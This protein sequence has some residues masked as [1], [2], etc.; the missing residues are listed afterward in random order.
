[1]NAEPPKNTADRAKP[2]QATPTKASKASSYV[3][4]LLIALAITAWMFTGQFKADTGAVA[5]AQSP[6]A[7][8]QSK[9]ESKPEKLFR[10]RVTPS[11]AEPRTSNLTIR[12][13]TKAKA[14]VQ[15]RAETAGKVEKIAVK[16]GAR[17][18]TGDLLCQ[19]D[20]GTRRATMAE[21][22]ASRVQ[23]QGDFAS[24][25]KLSRS[26]FTAVTKRRADKARLDAAKAAYARAELDMERTKVRAP[27]DG[28]VEA[29]PVKAGDYLRAT[30]IC[31]T[32][33]KLDPIL[34][35]GAIPE[36]DVARVEVGMNVR[37]ELV[38]GEE[39]TG[40]ITFISPSA[41]TNTRTFEF[42][43]EAANPKRKL[44][45]GVTADIII[46]L[47]AS[48]AHR[49][50]AS[51]LSLDDNGRIGLRLVSDDQTVRFMPVT[52]LSN[53]NDAV[54]VSGLPQTAQVITV[55]QE[56]VS[57]GQRVEAVRDET[58]ADG[59]NARLESESSAAL[60]SPMVETSPASASAVQRAPAVPSTE[61]KATRVT[62]PALPIRKPRA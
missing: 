39:V 1:M 10:V 27:F 7:T 61:K 48:D 36:R 59:D 23:A 4:A 11:K 33:V 2:E 17:V 29:Q 3:W 35:T 49:I 26:G 60:G 50:A 15:V 45:A 5:E 30:D 43:A 18:T 54:W 32:L 47:K 28:I 51:A 37:G 41:E 9:P 13:Q 31:A 52:I 46:P 20:M 44:R 25:Q 16:K 55:G 21:A 8:A 62:G 42:E 12:G 22:E 34:L 53:D 57:V 58:V 24:S 14:R 40:K 6:T 38:T 56:Y 19:I